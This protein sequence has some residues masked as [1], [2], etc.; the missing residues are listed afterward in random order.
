MNK[1]INNVKKF[2]NKADRTIF[3]AQH[4]FYRNMSDEAFI[5]KQYKN[6]FGRELDLINPLTYNEKLQWLKLKNRKPEYTKLVDKYEVKKYVADLIGEQYVIPT[7]GVWDKIED[8]EFDK[9]PNRF[10]LKCTHDSGGVVICDDKTKFN[11]KTA[12]KKLKKRFKHNYYAENREWIYKD[13]K[14]RII[15]ERFLD[16]PT[17]DLVD[18]KFLCFDGKP[19]LMFI[20]SERNCADKE[21]KFDFFDMQFNKLPFTNGHPNSDKYIEKPEQFDKMKELASV[22]SR[23]MPHVRIDFYQSEGK[24]YFGEITFFHW[25]GFTPFDPPEW[26]RKLGDMLKLPKSL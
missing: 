6:V 4:G 23:G 20:A 3:L 10:V 16:S 12:I 24:V 22:L 13:V 8:I 1:L 26:D 25:S 7:L 18:Y 17:G 15:A 5:K 11:K 19:E 14:R 2:L 21:T 9:L